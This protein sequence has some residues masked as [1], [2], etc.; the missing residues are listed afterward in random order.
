MKFIFAP[1]GAT[2][3]FCS[4]ATAQDRIVVPARNTAQP[5]KLDVH[6]TNGSVIV[7]AYGGKE[8]I[9]ETGDSRRNVERED[10]TVNGMHRIDL[11]PR[12]LTVEEENNTI[13]VRD[14]MS[15]A[16]TVTISV[17][18]DTS[19][20]A[21]SANGA[22]DVEGVSGEF[23]IQTNNGHVTLTDVSGSVL[24]NS[25]NG[26]IKVAMVKVDPAKPLSFS[27]LNGTIEV[28]LPATWKANVKLNTNHGEI[29]SDF[30]FKLNGGAAITQPNST[31]EG[32]FRVTMDRTISGTVN[33]GGPDATF[34]TFNGRIYIKKR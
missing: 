20:T 23:D 15:S 22:I 32:R 25:L 18:A 9:V 24:A 11:P 13:T 2:I 4:F 33:G 10:R 27:T 8:V 30:D 26:P 12:G 21:R 5:R 31:S 3:L 16:G 34:H 14:R 29:W 7:K 1:L 17:P 6:L 28:T 19:I